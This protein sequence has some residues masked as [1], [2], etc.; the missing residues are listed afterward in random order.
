MGALLDEV[1]EILA[2]FRGPEPLRRLFWEVLGYDRVNEPLPDGNLPG[3]IHST[4]K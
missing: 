2:D 1:R 3:K 4:L